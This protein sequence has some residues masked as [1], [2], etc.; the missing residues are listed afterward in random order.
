MVI[1][2]QLFDGPQTVVYPMKQPSHVKI[3]MKQPLEV[4]RAIVLKYR[5]NGETFI[6]ENLLNLRIVDST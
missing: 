2:A 3:L 6:E 5:G 1:L 4:P